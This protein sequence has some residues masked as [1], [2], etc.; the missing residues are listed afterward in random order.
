MDPDGVARHH[1]RRLARA[2]HPARSWPARCSSRWRP[3]ASGISLPT[4]AMPLAQRL[5][6][7][8]YGLLMQRDTSLLPPGESW[9]TLGARAL[10]AA[11]AW[12]TERLGADQSAWRWERIH[13]TRPRHPLSAVFPEHAEAARPAIGRRRRRRRHAAE[14][15]LRLRGR[16]RLHAH[17]HL[18]HALLLRPRQTGITAAGP[19]RSAAPATPAARTTPIR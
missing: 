14:R 13:R 11:V 12:L 8:F 4:Q 18:G 19:A 2:D 6:N 7:V 3:R 1:L 5:R 9:E 15:H 17:G 16:P 10:A